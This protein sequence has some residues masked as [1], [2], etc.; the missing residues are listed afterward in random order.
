M[1]ATPTIPTVRGLRFGARATPPS[2]LQEGLVASNLAE[3]WL[4]IQRVRHRK[5]HDERLA[6]PVLMKGWVAAFQRLTRP[7]LIRVESK[8]GHARGKGGCHHQGVSESDTRSTHLTHQ[9]PRRPGATS[10]SGK[11]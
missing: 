7:L 3:A 9:N 10:R 5:G 8:V 1:R 4:A 6:R 11:P 2:R